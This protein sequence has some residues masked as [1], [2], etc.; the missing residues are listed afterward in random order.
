MPFRNTFPLHFSHFS[1]LFSF[2]NNFFVKTFLGHFSSF[3]IQNHFLG[4]K[5]EGRKKAEKLRLSPGIQS[6]PHSTAMT[7]HK[8][9][10]EPKDKS[11]FKDP[12]PKKREAHDSKPLKIHIFSFLFG[13]SRQFLAAST[14]AIPKNTSI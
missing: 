1:L 8:A 14:P 12:R 10:P 9:H 11:T 4:P 13:F 7:R 3:S 6:N 5:Q 2:Q